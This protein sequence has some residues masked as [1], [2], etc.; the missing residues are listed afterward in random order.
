MKKNAVKNL[1]VVGLCLG[2]ATTLSACNKDIYD[3]T[4]KEFHYIVIEENDQ[5]ILHKIAGWCDSE[6]DS[7]TITTDCCKNYIWT[8]VNQATL[9][10]NMPEHYAYDDTCEHLYVDINN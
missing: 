3:W 10:K 9:Y 1:A 6:S 4:H 8:T 7:V 5:H 2:M